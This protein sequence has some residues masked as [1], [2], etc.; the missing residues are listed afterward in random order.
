MWWD[1]CMRASNKVGHGES[2]LAS[3]ITQ[4]NANV[5]MWQV[6]NAVRLVC[7]NIL[8]YCNIVFPKRKLVYELINELIYSMTLLLSYF[9]L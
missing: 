8:S 2:N 9:A 5:R 6:V 1:V 3:N 7:G 4:S